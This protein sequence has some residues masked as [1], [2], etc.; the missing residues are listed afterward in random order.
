MPALS[1]VRPAA[2]RDA[3]SPA[4]VCIPATIWDQLQLQL[5]LHGVGPDRARA[6]PRCSTA[7]SP[8]SPYPAYPLTRIPAS[9]AL[10]SL[11][12]DGHARFYPDRQTV[13]HLELFLILCLDA[14]QQAPSTHQPLRSNHPRY[15][16]RHAP[17]THASAHSGRVRLLSLSVS[18]VWVPPDGWGLGPAGACTTK[19]SHF[20][21]PKAPRSRHL[22]GR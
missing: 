18:D 19:R 1:R 20:P 10:P 21:K 22:P 14:E 8:F 16:A 9:R 7:L 6:C 17:T 11:S 4:P 12:D 3:V 5:Q 2:G 15:A 13:W